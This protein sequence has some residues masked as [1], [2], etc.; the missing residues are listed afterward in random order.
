MPHVLPFWLMVRPFFLKISN[1]IS[2]GC[3]VAFKAAIQDRHLIF[4]QRSDS[5][6]FFLGLWH[7]SAEVKKVPT[8]T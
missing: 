4:A 8:L 3:S 6:L 2:Y 7:T 1:A 5:C